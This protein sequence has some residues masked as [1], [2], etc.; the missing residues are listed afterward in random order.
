[1]LEREKMIWTKDLIANRIIEVVNNLG[2]DYMPTRNQ[3]RNYYGNDRLT[4]KISKTLGYYGWAAKLGLKNAE[5]D[6]K[7]GK[8]G[9]L[10]AL[11]ILEQ[12]GF[13]VKRMLQNYPFDL[14]IND[15]VKADVKFANLYRSKDGYGFYSFALR[16]PYPTCDVY[17]LIAHSQDGENKIF[18]VPS[19]DANQQQISI[20]EHNSIYDRYLMRMDIIRNYEAAFKAVE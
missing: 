4:N 12:Q 5:N 11:H 17:I 3:I 19:S 7:T 1:M 13:S 20:G 9:E 10:F 6:T 14:L 16:K 8:D 18:I 15:V 2:I